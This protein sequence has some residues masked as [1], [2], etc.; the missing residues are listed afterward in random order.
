MTLYIPLST[1]LADLRAACR[2]TCPDGDSWPDSSL[3]QWIVEGI[4]LYSAMFPRVRVHQIALATG[5]QSYSLPADCTQVL[6]VEYPTSASP[7][8]ILTQV[9]LGS[10]RFAEAGAVYALEAIQTDDLNEAQGRITFAQTVATGEYALLTY[11]GAW[12][13]PQVSDD[14]ALITIPQ[15]HHECI[16]AFVEYRCHWMLEANTAVDSDNTSLTLS[17]LGQNARRAWNRYKEVTARLQ[18]P[19][20]LSGPNPTWSYP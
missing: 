4:K 12:E 15:P 17:E 14:A 13:W 6:W 18:A 11:H 8:T 19:P 1:T 9:N 10:R 5:T 16:I 3:D 2:L 7:R 20:P